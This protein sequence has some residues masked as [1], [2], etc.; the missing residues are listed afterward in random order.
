MISRLQQLADR[1]QVG[2]M[3]LCCWFSRASDE[4]RGQGMVEYALILALIAVLVMV[5]LKFLQ[6]QISGTLNRVTTNL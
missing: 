3:R 4:Q 5:A 2:F 1:S 6:P